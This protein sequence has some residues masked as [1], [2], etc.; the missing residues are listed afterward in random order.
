MLC[1]VVQ[2]VSFTVFNVQFIKQCMSSREEDSS[3]SCLVVQSS[4]QC[5]EKCMSSGE[6]E[7]Q[8]CNVQSVQSVQ[9]SIYMLSSVCQTGRGEVALNLVVKNN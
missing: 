6:E 1:K 2:C 8:L 7:E 4:E 5:P 3:T 9:C